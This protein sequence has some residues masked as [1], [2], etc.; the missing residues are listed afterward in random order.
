MPLRLFLLSC[1]LLGACT[2][3]S[4][5]QETSS[6][7][8]R[9]SE[10]TPGE[11]LPPGWEAW[12][13][14]SFKKPTQYKIVRD[15]NRTVLKASANSSASGLIYKVGVDLSVRPYLTW[16]WKVPALI[17]SA[18]NTRKSK[19]DSPVRLVVAFKG[20]KASLP[21]EERLF[22]DQF[23]LFTRRELPYATLM[24]IWEN[25]LAEGT[26]LANPHTTRIKMIVA[27]TGPQRVGK[28]YSETRNVYEDYKR[29]F[30]EEPPPVKWVAVMTDTD[31][32]GSEVDAYYGD[33]AFLSAHTQLTYTE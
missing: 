25:R 15:G 6:T 3:S 16:R 10:A 20:D 21:F 32:T 22:A 23:K 29:A 1:L 28:W 33:I 30:G 19:E 27:E 17:E 8:G 26:V 7:V 13:F 2:T 12:T 18:D 24:Y 4:P 11:A 5:P 31:N 9:F 14:S